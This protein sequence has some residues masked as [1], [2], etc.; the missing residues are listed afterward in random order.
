MRVYMEID[1]TLSDVEIVIKT[2]Q[3]DEAVVELQEK[4][5]KIKPSSTV[6][7][8]YRQDSEYFVPLKDVLFFE[9]DG[10]KVYVH[11]M[12]KYY[13]VKEK[14]YQLE[15]VLPTHF[16]RISK[17]TLVNVLHI[18]A[19]D[20]SFSGTSTIR[21]YR[22]DKLVHVSR[23]YYRSLKEKLNEMRLFYEK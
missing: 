2:P 11:E 14:L 10:H 9:A 15:E 5:Q 20:R 1:K 12:E 8:A 4:L 6:L 19:L 13:E 23:H 17:S 21:F 18:Y 7:K 16:A 3:V 22:S